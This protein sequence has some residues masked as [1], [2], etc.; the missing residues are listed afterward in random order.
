MRQ[1]GFGGVGALEAL[2]VWGST[3]LVFRGISQGAV[4]TV[5]GHEVHLTN[6]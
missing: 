3:N 6:S 2:V 1:G 4:E 5:V